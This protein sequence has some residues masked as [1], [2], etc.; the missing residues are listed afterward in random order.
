MNLRSRHEYCNSDLCFGIIADVTAFMRITSI[1]KFLM[2]TWPPCGTCKLQNRTKLTRPQKVY[3]GVGRYRANCLAP[4]TIINYRTVRLDV[5][6][7][8]RHSRIV[9]SR[10]AGVIPTGAI[11]TAAIPTGIIRCQSVRRTRKTAKRRHLGRVG[12]AKRPSGR[13]KDL[14][15][16]L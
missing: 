14:H 10:Y 5:V 4:P 1:N 3:D 7:A 13:N 6:D 15:A 16:A 11:P 12:G 9:E 8:A 2:T